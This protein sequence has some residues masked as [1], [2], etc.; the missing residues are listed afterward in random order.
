MH[1]LSGLVL[2]GHQLTGRRLTVEDSGRHS[3][4]I[5][6]LR[7]CCFAGDSLVGDPADEAP[8]DP[9]RDFWII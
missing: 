5:E 7:G 1:T 4:G 3:N 6:R 8:D 9:V 2:F